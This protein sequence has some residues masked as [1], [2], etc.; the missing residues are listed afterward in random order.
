MLGDLVRAHRRRLGWS[1]E[2]LAG[3]TGVSVR[4][5]RKIEAQHTGTPRPVTVRLL[6]DAFGLQG[7]DRDRFCQ[8]AL[9]DPSGHAHV[10]AQ[11]P[12]APAAFVGRT[13]ELAGL[14]H[15]LA[16]AAA[17]AAAV[18]SA[19]SGTAGIG[20]TTLA[21]HWAHR[22]A[23]HFPGGQLYVNLRGYDPT[24][25]VVDP[26]EALCVFLDALDVP[27]DRIPSGLDA[28]AALYRS[29]LAGRRVLVVLDNARDA[30]QVRPLLPGTAGC[31][32]V[33]TSRDQLTGLTATEAA[34]PFTLQL[35]TAD[36]AHGLLTS[37]LGAARTTAEP[38]AVRDII[39]RCARLPL[40]LAVVAARA[41]ARPAFPLAALAA[42]LRTATTTLDGLAGGDP[43]TDLRAVFSWSQ[44]TLSPDA[45]RLFRLLGLHPGPDITAAAAASL[46]ATGAAQARSL[47]DELAQAHL[48]LE[49]V[50]GRYALHDLLRAFAAEQARSEDAPATHRLLDHY[51][52]TANAAARWM[53]PMWE[54]LTL[55]EPQPGVA[56]ESLDNQPAAMAWFTAEQPVL[57]AVVEQA[58]T[59]GFDGH[60]WQLAWACTAYLMRRAYLDELTAMQS[61]ALH[62]AHRLGD[63]AGQG[64]ALRG[65]GMSLGRA[66]RHEE[67]ESYYER[68][69]GTYTRVGDLLG[70]AR[71]HIGLAKAVLGQGRP[72]EALRVT[73]RALALFRTAGDRAGEARSLNGIGWCLA[74]LGDHERGLSYCGR[75]LVLF[76]EVGDGDG[77]AVTWDSI[78]H[79][80]C[81]LGEYGQAVASYQHAVELLHRLDDCSLLGV[82]LADLGDVHHA[83]GSRQAAA[84][85]WKEA[86]D[87][88]DEVGHPRAEP[89][90][91]KLAAG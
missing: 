51:L 1:Q 59:A 36:E 4:G 16:D 45:D 6:A 58:A 60:I 70:Q 91:A 15:L 23:R 61:L 14:D 29:V 31:F 25:S 30:A 73:E 69:L 89:V 66:G 57:Q 83:A 65:L 12:S 21:V 34:H 8:T 39:A 7:T 90:R 33:V 72:A 64:Y 67:A 40:A 11:L 53:H 88:L 56:P 55:P 10:P 47:L 41:A 2:D 28:R 63:P 75:A 62:A 78:G 77:L 32:A 43:A 35:L 79:I 42:D 37:R 86:L 27:A 18:I 22:A 49:H 19:V 20:K 54:R 9:G 13:L 17:P 50:P 76:R 81:R 26:A 85:A 84:L 52:W 87:V 82:T 46:A 24:G 44:R 5:I 80:Y 74:Q 68:A 71:A 3:R 38:E 48:I